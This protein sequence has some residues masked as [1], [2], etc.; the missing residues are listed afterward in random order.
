[1]NKILVI[2]SD[3]GQRT[4]ARVGV[5][6][7]TKIDESPDGYGNNTLY[8]YR[9][10]ELFMKMDSALVVIEYETLNYKEPEPQF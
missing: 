4:V 8:V 7:V 3:V 10:E 6:G 2:N 1:M 5:N 9:G